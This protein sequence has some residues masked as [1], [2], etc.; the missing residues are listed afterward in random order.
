M[1]SIFVDIIEKIIEVFMDDFSIYTTRNV[2]FYDKILRDG[3]LNRHIM[4]HNMTEKISLSQI[5]ES[6]VFCD[7][8]GCVSHKAIKCHH[9]MSIVISHLSIAFL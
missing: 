2:A 9:I 4:Y 5:G 1:M 7:D 3:A 8:V 6:H